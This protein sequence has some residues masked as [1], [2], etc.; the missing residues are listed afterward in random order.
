MDDL[1]C[2]FLC[3]F[4]PACPLQPWAV[5]TPCLSDDLL[6]TCSDWQMLRARRLGYPPTSGRGPQQASNA[7]RQTSALRSSHAFRPS[8]ALLDLRCS[9]GSKSTNCAH[10]ASSRTV[11]L[12]HPLLQPLYRPRQ[13]H[14]HRGKA[15][16]HPSHGPCRK[17]RHGPY[18]SN[19]DCSRR[20]CFSRRRELHTMLLVHLAVRHL[21]SVI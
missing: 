5:E 3:P 10:I 19:A 12:L 2:I 20:L 8:H 1:L 16:T 6:C 11:N 9:R 14:D 15:C 18:L 13:L 17:V 21:P 7:S 4:L